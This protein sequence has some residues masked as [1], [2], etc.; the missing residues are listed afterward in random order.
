MDQRESAD[1]DGSP[2]PDRCSA[3]H[4]FLKAALAN[5]VSALRALGDDTRYE[6]LRLVAGADEA[7]VCELAPALGVSQGAVS[8][9][10]SE[11]FGA[12]SVE[13]RKEGRWRYYSAT[14]RPNGSSRR[15]RWT[16]TGRDDTGSE[17]VTPQ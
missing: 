8:R 17:A 10:P 16:M 11:L 5:D 15:A 14:E 12:G 9:V 6:A 13:R 7:C 3:A 4:D 2:G 1:S